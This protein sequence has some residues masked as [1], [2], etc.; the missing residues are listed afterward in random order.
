MPVLN[1][2][3]E[4]KAREALP[5]FL[6]RLAA[7]NSLGVVECSKDMGFSFKRALNLEEVAL[8][9]L[10]EIAG[11]RAEQLDE[12]VSWTGRPA[13]DIRMQ[14]RAE[15]VPSRALR[16]PVVRGCLDCLRAD[17]VA[18]SAAPLTAMTYR[19]EWQLKDAKVCVTHNRPLGPLWEED[20]PL[21]RWDFQ[22]RFSNLQATLN[23]AQ[24]E[25]TPFNVTAYDLWLD[26]RLG[27]GKDGTWFKGHTVFAAARLSKCIGQQIM[28][29]GLVCRNLPV[30][31]DRP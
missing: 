20:T 7:T 1:L 13:G 12:L 9:T 24:V 2:T 18:Q 26:R 31:Q 15:L 8:R 29:H 21:R 28:D 23:A 22:A 10:A 17:I 5:S 14:F 6:S 16:S 25:E 19:G 4:P 11:L 3:L 27:T 30:E